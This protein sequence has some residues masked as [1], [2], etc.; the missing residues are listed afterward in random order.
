MPKTISI[1]DFTLVN[2]ASDEGLI[3]V[4]NAIVSAA[5]GLSKTSE[6]LA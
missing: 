1:A 5:T 6:T 4:I 3:H 2:H